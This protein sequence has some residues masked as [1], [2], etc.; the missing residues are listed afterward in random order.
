MKPLLALALAGGCSS[1][2]CTM[3]VSS[4][5][6]E[7]AMGHVFLEGTF[8]EAQPILVLTPGSGAAVQVVCP[9]YDMSKMSAICDVKAA[10]VPAGTYKVTF[11]MTCRD[12]SLAKDAIA[13]GGLVPTMLTIN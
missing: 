11:D 13:V 10:G 2:I 6:T 7:D 1:S 8:D 9:P 12:T 3:D 5:T 4:A